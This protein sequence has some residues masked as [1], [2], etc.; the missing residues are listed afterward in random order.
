MDEKKNR[1]NLFIAIGG[2]QNERNND[3]DIWIS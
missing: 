1:L 2:T 3:T